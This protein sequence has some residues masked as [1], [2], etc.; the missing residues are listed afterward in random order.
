MGYCEFHPLGPSAFRLPG[1]CIDRREHGL[2]RD[3]ELGYSLTT[4]GGHRALQLAPDGPTAP[5]S[6]SEFATSLLGGRRYQVRKRRRTPHW[7]DHATQ[8][9]QGREK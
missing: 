5:T 7:C 3:E 2:V 9:E 4:S 1:T 6:T 8:G